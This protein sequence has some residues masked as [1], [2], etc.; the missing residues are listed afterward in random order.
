MDAMRRQTEANEIAERR[1]YKR[2]HYAKEKA[3]R[4]NY[5]TARS[6]SVG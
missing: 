1:N 6:P 3:Q 5:G 4:A 2:M